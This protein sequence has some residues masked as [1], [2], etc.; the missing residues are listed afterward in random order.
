M[1]ENLRTKGRIDINTKKSKLAVVAGI[2]IIVLL[3]I[4][5]LTQRHRPAQVTGYTP[6][7]PSISF[8]EADGYVEN[9]RQTASI[10]VVTT[11]YFDVG[12]QSQEV[13]ITNEDSN[14]C[15]FVVSLYL[16]DGTK[17]FETGTIEPGN[18]VKVVNL[19]SEVKSGTYN[20]A[21]LVYTCYSTDGSMTPL[22]RCEFVIS[23]SVS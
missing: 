18:S 9:E 8:G 22:T 14:P 3:I 1:Q 21:L 23:I 15:A 17:L 12:S 10:P 13:D 6:S 16:A 4:L 7:M 11:M 5:L 19:E 20:D 2:A